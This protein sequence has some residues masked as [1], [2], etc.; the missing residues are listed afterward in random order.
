MY[1][2]PVNLKKEIEIIKELPNYQSIS[3]SVA[4]KPVHL[5]TMPSATFLVGNSKRH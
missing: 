2:H 5:Y 3:I 1:K 4:K